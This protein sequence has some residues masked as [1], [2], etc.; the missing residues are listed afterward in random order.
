M[1]LLIKEPNFIISLGTSKPGQNNYK[2]S[3]NNCRSIRKNG[4]FSRARNL[5]LEKMYNKM[6]RRAYKTIG[7][8]I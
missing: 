7:L 5:I 1:F 2:V 4:I 3:T 8:A 6:V